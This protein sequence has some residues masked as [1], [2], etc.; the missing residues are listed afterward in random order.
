MIKYTF[1]IAYLLSSSKYAS[2]LIIDYGDMQAFSDSFRGIKDQKILKGEEL[3]KYSGECDLTSY[4]NFRAIKNV[5]LRNSNIKFGGLMD[6]GD[7][8]ECLGIE[9]RANDLKRDLNLNKSEIIDRQYHRLVDGDE[10]GD[11][12]KFLYAHKSNNNPVFPFID[13]IMDYI[14]QN[15]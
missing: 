8:L 7:F 2:S 5:L 12:Y 14:N 13:E 4:V 10:M 9:N 15:K 6:Q 11:T 1:N 3:L